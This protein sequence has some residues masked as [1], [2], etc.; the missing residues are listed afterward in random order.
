MSGDSVSAENIAVIS[1]K[2]CLIDVRCQGKLR[3]ILIC[4]NNMLLYPAIEK[5]G[6]CL[7]GVEGKVLQ[8]VSD[9]PLTLLFYQGAYAHC[10]S[11]GCSVF[12]LGSMRHIVSAAGFQ[13]I[14]FERTAVC[15]PQLPP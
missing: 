12:G 6:A 14:M 3:A 8:D 5:H 10:K 9:T 7:S 1:Q 11:E 15:M 2:H 4:G 13:C